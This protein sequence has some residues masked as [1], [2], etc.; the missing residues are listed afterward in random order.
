MQQAAPLTTGI[1]GQIHSLYTAKKRLVQERSSRNVTGV[2]RGFD[3]VR[4]VQSSAN[5]I[6]DF[7]DG[8][9]YC[10]HD[11]QDDGAHDHDQQG[12]QNTE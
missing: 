9:Q 1:C 6:I 10:K 11:S 4:T 3:P 12:L 2:S 5:Q 7:K 8:Q